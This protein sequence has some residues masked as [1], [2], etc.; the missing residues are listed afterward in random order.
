MGCSVIWL[1][2]TD[3]V[4]FYRACMFVC[5]TTFVWISSSYCFRTSKV[6][7]RT[8]FSEKHN[9]SSKQHKTQHNTTQHNTTLGRPVVCTVSVFAWWARWASVP[10]RAHTGSHTVMCWRSFRRRVSSVTAAFDSVLSVCSL[11]QY[12][13]SLIISGDYFTVHTLNVISNGAG[14]S[15]LCAHCSVHR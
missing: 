5:K 10:S 1:V 4:L 14:T 2:E 9:T 11:D 6:R 3:Q 12:G 13:P 15:L 7:T 8:D